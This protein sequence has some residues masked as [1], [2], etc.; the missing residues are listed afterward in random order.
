MSSRFRVKCM[1]FMIMRF[2][3]FRVNASRI[4]EQGLG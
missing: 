1:L 3:G 2:V 4:R